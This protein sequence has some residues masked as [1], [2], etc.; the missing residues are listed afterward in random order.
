MT[1][2]A[3]LDIVNEAV[4]NEEQARRASR[5]KWDTIN[6]ILARLD[7]WISRQCGFC[8]LGRY[9]AENAGKG[10]T[11][12]CDY[13]P[14]DVKALCETIDGK[15]LTQ[16]EEL[17]A[18]IWSVIHFLQTGFTVTDGSAEDKKDV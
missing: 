8:A 3:D 5:M 16:I 11:A 14:S 15:I 12:R 4:T 18:S 2:L 17:E 6:E 13:C 9:R 10:K 1:T 7:T